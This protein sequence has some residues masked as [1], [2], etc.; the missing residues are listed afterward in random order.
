MEFNIYYEN[1]LEILWLSLKR[2]NRFFTK[3][4]NF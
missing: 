3:N 2:K 4:L 1:K